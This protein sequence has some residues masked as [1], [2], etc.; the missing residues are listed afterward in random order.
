MGAG[1]YGVPLDLCA[2]VMLEVIREQVLGPTSLEEV[3]ICVIDRRE[4]S[5][6]RERMSDL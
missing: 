2:R 4:F 5:A 6:F 3:V 1:F